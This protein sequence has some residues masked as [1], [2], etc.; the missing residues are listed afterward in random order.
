MYFYSFLFVQSRLAFLQFYALRRK[1]EL[2][3]SWSLISP[4]S[5][6]C[7]LIDN[8]FIYCMQ[9][10]V[11]NWLIKFYIYLFFF[12][13]LYL[14]QSY[15]LEVEKIKYKSNNDYSATHRHF[16]AQSLFLKSVHVWKWFLCRGKEKITR[17][18][19]LFNWRRW[20]LW[21]ILRID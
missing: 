19:K 16:F 14:L 1:I 17:A 21:A 10:K 18:T 8:E 20:D 15:Q 9:Y 11:S 6:C 4:H 13:Q 2:H 5:C 12:F 7:C 3:I